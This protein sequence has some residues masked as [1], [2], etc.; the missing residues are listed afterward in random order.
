MGRR[1]H[2]RNMS[3]RNRYR[4]GVTYSHIADDWAP[5]ADHGPEWHATPEQTSEVVAQLIRVGYANVRTVTR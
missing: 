2:T 5:S 4:T 1:A 3:N